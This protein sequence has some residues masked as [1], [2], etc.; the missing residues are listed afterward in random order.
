MENSTPIITWFAE[1]EDYGKDT[2]IITWFQVHNHPCS[3][4]N[5]KDYGKRCSHNH[6]VCQCIL[7]IMPPCGQGQN[8]Q[9]HGIILYSKADFT[10]TGMG[11]IHIPV[12][13]DFLIKTGS[14]HGM[15][16]S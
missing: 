9:N 3:Y 6:V 1:R 4:A 12:N 16:Q 10:M 2:P 13:N 11:N 7:E 8:R 5:R 15:K 14:C